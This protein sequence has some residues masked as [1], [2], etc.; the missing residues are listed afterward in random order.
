MHADHHSHLL[1]SSRLVKLLKF[2]NN[3]VQLSDIVVLIVCFKLI[4]FVFRK[5]PFFVTEISTTIAI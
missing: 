1:L 2:I 5:L 4:I 3:S